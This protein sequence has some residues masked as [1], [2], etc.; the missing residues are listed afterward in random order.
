MVLTVDGL[1]D[2]RGTQACTCMAAAKQSKTLENT[3]LARAFCWDSVGLAAV[4]LFS[5]LVACFFALLMWVVLLQFDTSQ[6]TRIT[7]LGYEYTLAVSLYLLCTGESAGHP[8]HFFGRFQQKHL[9]LAFHRGCMDSGL[10]AY[11]APM[12]ETT[13]F[14]NA[15]A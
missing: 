6:L 7:W 15:H 4:R 5:C 13:F 11:Q 3:A 9:F 8:Q 12:I 10:W 1:H 2:T 14:L